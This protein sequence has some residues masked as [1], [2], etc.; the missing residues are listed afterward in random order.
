MHE[1]YKTV[2]KFGI[3][4]E[5]SLRKLN[6][7]PQ[8]FHAKLMNWKK[9]RRQ[10][11]TDFSALVTWLGI[12]PYGITDSRLEQIKNVF[13]RR[14]VVQPKP[15]AVVNNEQEQ[16]DADDQWEREDIEE[17]LRQRVVVGDDLDDQKTEKDPKAPKEVK[18]PDHFGLHFGIKTSSVLAEKRTIEEELPSAQPTEQ[19]FKKHKIN[20]HQL[21]IEIITRLLET[22]PPLNAAQLRAVCNGDLNAV[23]LSDR[24]AAYNAWKRELLDQ[25]GQKERKLEAD[26]HKCQ[27][28]LAEVRTQ[29]RAEICRPADIVGFTTSGAAK[30]RA[31]IGHLKPN[32]GKAHLIICSMTCSNFFCIYSHRRR[33]CPSS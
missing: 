15:V 20:A 21:Q 6:I 2:D 23:P 3:V 25:L 19:E 10:Q 32:I 28:E 33:S 27:N 30:Q 1:L 16:V 5:D 29:E 31:L 14:P 11:Q 18:I 8:N 12:H 13:N 7:L 17:I 9:N 24:W 22:V 4:H 26:F